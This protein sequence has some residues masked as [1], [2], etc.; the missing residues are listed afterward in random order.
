MNSKASLAAVGR[1]AGEELGIP[2]AYDRADFNQRLAAAQ[3]DQNDRGGNHRNRSRR[4]HGDAQLAMIRVA[5]EYVVVRH[6]DE[7]QKRQQGQTQ[8]SG[9]PKSLW[10]AA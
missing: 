1:R 2:I 8:Q 10:P 6:L 7:G 3:D 9:S 4:V 5:L